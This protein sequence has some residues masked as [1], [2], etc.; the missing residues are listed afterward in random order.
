MK[1]A[2]VLILA[3]CMLLCLFGCGGSKKQTK[4]TLTAAFSS[5]RGTLDPLYYSGF[6]I[7]NLMCM[8]YEPLWA[9]DYD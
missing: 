9:Y 6:D 8:V 5:D 3:V 1:R 4:D 2:I 7:Q